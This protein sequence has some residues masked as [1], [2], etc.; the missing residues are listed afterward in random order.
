MKVWSRVPALLFAFVWG[1]VLVAPI[2]ASLV[3][4]ARAV[5]A[6]CPGGTVSDPITGV[7]WSSNQYNLGSGNVPCFPGRLGLC[8][9]ALQNAPVPGAALTPAPP[10]GPAP[11][12]TWPRG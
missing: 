2:C 9:G 11:R 4:S 6:P 3:L 5:A 1:L 10:A 12:S 8:L 7:C